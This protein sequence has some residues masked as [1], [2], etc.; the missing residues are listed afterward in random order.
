[1]KLVEKTA[2]GEFKWQEVFEVESLQAF[3]DKCNANLKIMF[4][5]KEPR[6]RFYLIADHVEYWDSKGRL[7]YSFYICKGPPYKLL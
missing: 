5:G 7:V 4:S 3:A 2:H 6:E 1:M